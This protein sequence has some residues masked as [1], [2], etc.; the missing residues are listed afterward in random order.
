ML[1]ETIGANIPGPG[2]YTYTQV[3]KSVSGDM[4]GVRPSSAVVKKT[5][6]GP[7]SYEIIGDFD[8]ST[9]QSVKKGKLKT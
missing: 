5:N 9:M 2:H 8:R 3:N 1:D 4:F 6:L 7:G